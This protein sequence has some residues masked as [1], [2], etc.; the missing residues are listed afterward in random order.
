MRL[1]RRKHETEVLTGA[2][3]RQW[4]AAN[5]PGSMVWAACVALCSC[6]WYECT[7]HGELAEMKAREHVDS[8]G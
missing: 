1:L 5:Q 6:G 7:I 8:H 4:I 2:V 3:A